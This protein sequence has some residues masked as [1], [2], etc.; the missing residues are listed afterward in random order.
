[1]LWKIFRLSYCNTCH[2]EQG[3]SIDEP[4]TIFDANTPYVDRYWVYTAISRARELDK[5]TIY[6]HSGREIAKLEES[7]KK[8]Y[9]N[10]KIENYRDQDK[11]AS[12]EID[13][14]KYVDY[15]WFVNESFSNDICYHCGC[16]FELGLDE[17]NNVFSNITF[18]RIDNSLAHNKDNLVLSCLECNRKKL[19]IR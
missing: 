12:R 5:V 6:I 18:D 14:K 7:K 17:H 19:K 8:Q 11:L 10:M 3:C 16:G 2:S 1:M 9:I 4:I 15:N 13:S